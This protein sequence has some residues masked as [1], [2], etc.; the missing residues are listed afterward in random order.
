MADNLSNDPTINRFLQLPD[1]VV[2]E[3]ASFLNDTAL[4]R[5][6]RSSKRFAFLCKDVPE[7][8]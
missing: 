1:E 7:L 2:V 4:V 5:L 3:I 8:R 6:C